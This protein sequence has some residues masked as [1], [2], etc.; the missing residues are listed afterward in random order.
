MRAQDKLKSYDALGMV[1]EDNKV[2]KDLYALREQKAPPKHETASIIK[3]V[4]DTDKTDHPDTK[5][6]SNAVDAVINAQGRP[7][8]EEVIVRRGTEAEIGS[9]FD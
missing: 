1:I 3:S 8:A 2:K 4:I 7:R 5:A 9:S 6:N